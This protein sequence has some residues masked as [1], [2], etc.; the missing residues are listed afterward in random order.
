MSIDTHDEICRELCART[1][2][3]VMSVGYRLAPE[4][5][6]PAGPDDCITATK[7]LIENAGKYKG[8]GER[9]AVA[10]D[11]AGGY[12]AAYTAQKLSAEGIR[13]KAQFLAYPVTDHY[14]AHHAAG[15]PVVYKNYA[16]V[17]GFLGAGE[18]GQE[19]MDTACGFLRERLKG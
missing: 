4:H 1:G 6:Y 5:P 19:A 16:N 17:Q 13:L 14:S 9:I 18:M 12:M 8:I 11:S 15:V 10:G 7:W 2:A 3:V